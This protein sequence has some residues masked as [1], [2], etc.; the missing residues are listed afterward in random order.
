MNDSLRRPKTDEYNEFY[1]GYV[2]HVPDGDLFQ[3][4]ESQI[5]EVRDCFTGKSESEFSKLHPPYTWTL[6]Q[7]VGHL[8]D[9]E[10]LF[11]WRAHRFG[12]GDETP[13]P[14]MNQNPYVDALD[15]Q[16][17]EMEALVDELDFAR[18]ANISFLRRLAPEDWDRIGTADGNPITVRALAYILVGHINHHFAIVRKRLK[19]SQP[20]A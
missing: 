12:C 19:Q 5:R 3:Q 13:L 15:Y 20:D 8:I 6:K 10:K 18:K 7:V 4:L 17:I 2:Q 11:G 16:S 9:A 14:G 1:A